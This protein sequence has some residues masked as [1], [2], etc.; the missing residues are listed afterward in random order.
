MDFITLIL[1]VHF[2][3]VLF[4]SKIFQFI[5][6]C[7]NWWFHFQTTVKNQLIISTPTCFQYQIVCPDVFTEYRHSKRPSWNNRW[8]QHRFLSYHRVVINILLANWKIKTKT[9]KDFSLFPWRVKANWRIQLLLLDR[10]QN[11]D[12]ASSQTTI[13]SH[14]CFPVLYSHASI[15][16]DNTILTSKIPAFGGI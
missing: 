13:L 6:W 15:E 3:V 8:K 1:I 12:C 5:L 7:L 10:K 11:T 9:P 14:M 4:I 16:Q 2:F